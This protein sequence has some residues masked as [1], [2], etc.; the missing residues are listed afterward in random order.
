[1]ATEMVKETTAKQSMM[2]RG[3]NY[4]AKQA[5]IEKDEKELE[6]LMASQSPSE[7]PQEDE[8]VAEVP[9]A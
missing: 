9:E 7:A 5:R 8:E 4:A 3:S 1:M 2:T 6:E